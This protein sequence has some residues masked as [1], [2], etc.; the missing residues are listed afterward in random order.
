ML[1]DSTACQKILIMIDS[2]IIFVDYM[3]SFHFL[4]IIND[5]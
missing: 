2:M 1:Y 4:F 5:C 3:T